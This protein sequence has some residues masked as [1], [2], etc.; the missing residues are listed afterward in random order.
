MRFVFPLQTTWY[1]LEI[2]SFI[3]LK[4]I[5]SYARDY[6][7][8]WKEEFSRV[9]SHGLKWG[10]KPPSRKRAIWNNRV[11]IG[12]LQLYWCR[13]QVAAV[14][15]IMYSG[16]LKCLAVCSWLCYYDWQLIGG[17]LENGCPRWNWSFLEHSEFTVPH[18]MMFF[19]FFCHLLALELDNTVGSNYSLVVLIDTYFST[20]EYLLKMTESRKWVALYFC[21]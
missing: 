10:N 12:R 14:F 8:I 6:L 16:K 9:S 19:F 1:S 13:F 18:Y 4:I 2:C 3:L 20:G 21:W 5:Y 17:K 11:H 15:A 7:K